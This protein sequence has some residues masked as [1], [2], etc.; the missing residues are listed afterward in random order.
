MSHIHRDGSSFLSHFSALHRHFLK[1]KHLFLWMI[2]HCLIF[3]LFNSSSYNKTDCYR[4]INISLLIV[5]HSTCPQ[6]IIFIIIINNNI[7]TTSETFTERKNKD[8]RVWFFYFFQKITGKS[9][10]HTDEFWAS[11]ETFA[12]KKSFIKLA[13][14]IYITKHNIVPRR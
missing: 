1:H 9:P 4:T 14:E 2:H 13:C 11:D 8:G 3:Y 10:Y 12:C 6:F 7:L 5:W